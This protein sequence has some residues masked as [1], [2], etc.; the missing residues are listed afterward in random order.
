MVVFEWS[1]RAPHRKPA[2]MFGDVASD[3]KNRLLAEEEQWVFQIGDDKYYL[4]SM[5]RYYPL[6]FLSSVLL[7]VSDNGKK[8]GLAPDSKYRVGTSWDA[9][10]PW[11]SLLGRY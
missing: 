2:L 4:P 7:Q 8:D 1:N 6:S 3:T 9:P 5:K 11:I 10:S